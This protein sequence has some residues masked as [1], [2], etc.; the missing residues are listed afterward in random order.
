MTRL[1]G[2]D[3][4]KLYHHRFDRALGEAIKLL[5]DGRV[6]EAKN[7]LEETLK[8]YIYRSKIYP[9]GERFERFLYNRFKRGGVVF[10][11]QH[12]FGGV[13][14]LVFNKAPQVKLLECKVS[15]RDV[16][17]VRPEDYAKLHAKYHQLQ[18]RGFTAIPIVVVRFPHRKKVRHILMK[19]EWMD[20][21]VTLR[22]E[23]REK[24]RRIFVTIARS[25]RKKYERRAKFE[26]L[27]AERLKLIESVNVDK[28]EALEV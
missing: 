19:D 3:D 17:H 9:D 27:Q 22:V 24:S 28:E 7:K 1:P 15:R 10:K 8:S 18:T 16:F 20:R 13:D 25:R 5:E 2:A 4:V 23:Y 11:S 6:D 21:E 12:S 14:I 26:R